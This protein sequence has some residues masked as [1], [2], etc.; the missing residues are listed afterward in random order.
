VK[1]LALAEKKNLIGDIFRHFLMELK[2]TSKISE[3]PPTKKQ[4]NS[5]DF[6]HKKCIKSPKKQKSTLN[7]KN[8]S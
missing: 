1:I 4:N 3:I 7:R 6:F 2:S 8:S 5:P